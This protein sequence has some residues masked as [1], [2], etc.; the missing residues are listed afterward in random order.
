MSFENF[1]SATIRAGSFFDELP[2]ASAAAAISN[3]FLNA[4]AGTLIVANTFVQVGRG[5]T[6]FQSGM[7]SLGYLVA[8]LLMIRVGEKFMQKSGARKPMILGSILAAV[9][10]GLLA[11]TF[12]PGMMYIIVAFIGFLI[13]GIGLGMYAT[14]STD[15]A[16]SN[17]PLEKAGSAS[18]IF[19]MSSSLGSSFG[20]AI[21]ASVYGS[22]SALGN[23]EM[24]GSVGILSNVLFAILALASVIFIV[25]RKEKQPE[26]TYTENLTD[27]LA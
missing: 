22:L 15:T 20:V 26:S 6:A 18:G 25:P 11:L 7:L 10:T 12:L 17:V 2:A 9:G 5:L 16:I 8:V 23:I 1:Q 21:S 14:P 3:F 24:A 27:R 13:F 4:V 19:K